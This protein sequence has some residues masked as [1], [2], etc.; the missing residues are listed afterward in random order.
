M[1]ATLEYGVLFVTVGESEIYIT[2]LLL[3]TFS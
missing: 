3:K 1:I 2:S